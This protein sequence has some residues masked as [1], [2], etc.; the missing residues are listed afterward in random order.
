MGDVHWGMEEEAD[1]WEGM[2]AL[3]KGKGRRHPMPEGHVVH[4]RE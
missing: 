3:R 4:G 2:K 1:V